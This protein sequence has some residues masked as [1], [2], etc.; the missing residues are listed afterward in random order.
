MTPEEMDA[1]IT[2][3]L[4]KIRAEHLE[5]PA[6]VERVRRLRATWEACA[7]RGLTPT[8]YRESTLELTFPLEVVEHLLAALGA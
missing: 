1:A 2:G 8:S 4:A 7:R 3:I 6:R 5:D